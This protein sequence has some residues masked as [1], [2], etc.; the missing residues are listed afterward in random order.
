MSQNDNVKMAKEVVFMLPNEAMKL[1]KGVSK[2][3]E[4]YMATE[5]IRYMADFI[6]KNYGRST[7][8]EKSLTKIKT[9]L[10]EK[11]YTEAFEELQNAINIDMNYD[12][13]TP[14]LVGNAMVEVL[15]DRLDEYGIDPD[16]MTKIFAS[17]F[18]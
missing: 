15:S 9:H 2:T 6:C 7:F 5:R 16:I 8:I 17:Q 14:L 3:D 12:N 13:Q 18:S 1:I 4:N 11:E 10:L